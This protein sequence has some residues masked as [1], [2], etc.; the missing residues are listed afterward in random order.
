MCVGNGDGESQGQGDNGG[1]SDGDCDGDGDGDLEYWIRES[2][3]N[4]L[5][6]FLLRR[7]VNIHISNSAAGKPLQKV[8][9][10][11]LPTNTQL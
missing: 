8:E 11:N 10:D 3:L 4:R 6:V 2:R 5:L 1:E 7:L 9:E